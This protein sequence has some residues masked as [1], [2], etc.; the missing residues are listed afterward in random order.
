MNALLSDESHSVD[1]TKCVIVCNSV[2]DRRE[3]FQARFSRRLHL[4]S[5]VLKACLG[6]TAD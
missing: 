5:K 4:I 6:V 2:R 3:E 1:L